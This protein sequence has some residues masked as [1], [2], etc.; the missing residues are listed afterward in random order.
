VT[1]HWGDGTSSSGVLDEALGTI[2]GTHAYAAPG[3]YVVTFELSD[4]GGNVVTSEAQVSVTRLRLVDDPENPGQQIL[5]VGGAPGRDHIEFHA[6]NRGETIE[7]R[8]N[9]RTIGTFDADS[10]SRLVAFGGDGSDHI[11]VDRR[12]EIP[13]ELH[14][15]NG[16]D[17][18]RGGDGPTT[19]YGG[20]GHDRIRTGSGNDYIDAGSGHDT[21]RSGRGQD[22]LLGR[23]GRDHLIGNHGLDLILGGADFDWL[24]GRWSEDL[25]IH[26]SI[27]IDNDRAALE[28]L[29]AA[30]TSGELWE[31][32]RRLNQRTGEVL[33]TN[34]DLVDSGVTSRV[35]SHRL[36]HRNC[37]LRDIL[38]A[39]NLESV[40]DD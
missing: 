16:R 15:G 25:V 3:D 38:F 2:A 31:Q 22:I 35:S 26:S 28:L 17:H 30:V 4:A 10:L 23:D 19:V 18:I 40:L 34:L 37:V 1:I 24:P 12:I 6:G 32:C 39:A 7:V 8:L 36:T 9:H 33:K 13:A 14:G 11:H 21:V 5:F 20:P 27:D 29:L